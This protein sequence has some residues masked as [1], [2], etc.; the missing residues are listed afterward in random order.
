MTASPIPAARVSGLEEL[1]EWIAVSAAK[2]ADRFELW[3]KVRGTEQQRAHVAVHTEPFEIADELLARVERDGRA[4]SGQAAYAVFAYRGKE[5]TPLERA[6]V[7]PP[8]SAML[9][10]GSYA[11]APSAFAAAA[12]DPATGPSLALTTV[13]ATMHQMTQE[14]FATLQRENAHQ[15]NL[16][17]SL[18][19]ASTGHFDALA[20]SYERVF[21]DLTGRHDAALR[22]ANDHR[23]QRRSAEDELAGVVEKYKEVLDQKASEAA[24]AERRTKVTTF[25][26]EQLKVLL[27]VLLAKVAGV[28]VD[29][30]TIGGAAVGSLLDS[31]TD[32]QK[33]TI[34]GALGNEQKI[35]LYEI[36]QARA[37][38]EATAK[39]DGAPVAPSASKASASPP[40]QAPSSMSSTGSPSTAASPG[41]SFTAD[42]ERD[43][44]RLTQLVENPE[45][46]AR[47]E[48]WLEH[49][50]AREQGAEVSKVAEPPNAPANDTNGASTQTKS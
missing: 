18:M 38:K 17:E 31:L 40:T 42:E 26:A 10:V 29:A 4:E 39:K 30:G 21:G 43:F 14:V 27:P 37:Q 9:T 15:R 48:A 41:S 45:Q 2:G 34:L 28:P 19:R 20:K 8:P 50:V 33:A 32:A 23:A 46:Q 44:E 25:A 7:S 22:E 12:A 47:Y 16:N 11:A 35:A 3:S 13:L 1:S 36:L 6:F 49:K 24:E 5:K